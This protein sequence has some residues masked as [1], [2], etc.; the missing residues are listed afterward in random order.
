[1]NTSARRAEQ[2]ARLAAAPAVPEQER[3]DVD[4]DAALAPGATPT[5]SADRVRGTYDLY[6]VT[7]R[8][9]GTDL[10]DAADELGRTR[11]TRQDGIEAAIRLIRR[12]ESVRR[13]WVAELRAIERERS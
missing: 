1:M 7:Y 11:V 9:F 4:R 6:P 8:G 10:L 5:P 13:R 3:A 12:D 2:A